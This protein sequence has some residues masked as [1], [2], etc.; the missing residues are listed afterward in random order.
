MIDFYEILWGVILPPIL[1]AIG[2]AITAYLPATR[3]FLSTGV[4]LALVIGISL[5]AFRHW[6]LPVWPYTSNDVHFWP[7]WIAFAAGLLTSCSVC[8]HGPLIWRVLARLALV[9]FSSWLLLWQQLQYGST[10]EA[11]AW[12]GGVTVVWTALVLAWERVHAATTQGVSV[13]ALTTLAGVSAVSLLLFNSATHGQY[14]GIL[15]AA[16][17]AALVLSWW[18]PTWY[19]ASGPVT[20]SALVLPT[21]WL[22][23]YRYVNLPLWALPL[24]AVAALAP[25]VA[26]I[27]PVRAWSDWKRLLVAVVATLVVVSPVLIWGVITS[28]RASA[29]PSYGY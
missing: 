21:L 12:I 22:L 11:V 27:A 20:V 25:F 16:L 26:T 29:A 18:K 28:I 3:R 10:G 4:L 7:A 2:M 13:T 14:G 17:T 15:T 6:P 23:G 8:G 9:G 1:M 5:L 19:A 24:F